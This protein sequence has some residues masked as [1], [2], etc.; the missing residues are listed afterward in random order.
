[1]TGLARRQNYHGRWE[2]LIKQSTEVL[3]AMFLLAGKNLRNY[4]IDQ[5]GVARF[6]IHAHT[7]C[8]W[9]GSLNATSYVYRFL[10]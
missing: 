7:L 10:H 6:I 5:V 2:V 4:I 3:N 9:L 1:M 8:L